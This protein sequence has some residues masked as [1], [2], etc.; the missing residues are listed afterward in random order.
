[1]AHLCDLEL[2]HRALIAAYRFRRID[3]HPGAILTKPL[4]EA[5]IAIISTAGLYLPSQEPFRHSIRH[6]DCS[7]REIPDETTIGALEIGQSSDAFDH[8]GIE[9]DRNLTFP[10]DRLHEAVEAG[11]IGAA[12]P[13]HF[14]I[15]GSIIAPAA[16]I[17]DTGP[18]IAD[19]LHE[20]RTDAVLLVPV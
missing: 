5:S 18:A 7:Y 8:A 10:L 6:D 12:A 17:R 20:D 11:L 19:R 3:W 4:N 9:S 1:M 16:L 13:R 2:K 14:S 15:M